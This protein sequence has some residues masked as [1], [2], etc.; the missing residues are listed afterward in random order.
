MDCEIGEV[1]LFYNG[2]MFSLN[3]YTDLGSDLPV[4]ETGNN[5]ITYSDT[6]TEVKIIPK[7][8]KL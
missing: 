4:L 8:W 6:F 3:K 5:N 2:T 1:Y 7:W